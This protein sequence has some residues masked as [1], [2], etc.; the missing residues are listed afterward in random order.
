MFC[1]KKNE[2]F[3]DI[4]QSFSEAKFSQLQETTVGTQ[5]M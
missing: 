5:T 1:E 2:K 4:C 3:I